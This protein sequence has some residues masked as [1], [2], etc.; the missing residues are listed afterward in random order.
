MLQIQVILQL[1]LQ[2]C[3]SLISFYSNA[4]KPKECLMHSSKLYER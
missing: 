1:A 3:G 4:G 2:Q